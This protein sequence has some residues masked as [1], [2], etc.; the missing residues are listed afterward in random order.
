MNPAYCQLGSHITWPTAPTFVAVN[1]CVFDNHRPAIEGGVLLGLGPALPERVGT[2]LCG[3]RRGH[4]AWY[5]QDMARKEFLIRG[6][7][8]IE[9]VGF[10]VAR[11]EQE[12]GGRDK[13]DLGSVSKRRGNSRK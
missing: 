4:P 2:V 12:L 6:E 3:A 10:A 9:D 7:V 1:E 5:A 13:E 8:G 11:G